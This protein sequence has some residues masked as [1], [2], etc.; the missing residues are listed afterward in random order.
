MAEDEGDKVF[1]E[2]E[3]DIENY[4]EWEVLGRC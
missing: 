1:E 4:G 3:V 2:V